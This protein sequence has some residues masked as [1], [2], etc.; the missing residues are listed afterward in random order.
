MRFFRVLFST[1]A[2]A[3]L[4]FNLV[5]SLAAGLYRPSISERGYLVLSAAVASSLVIFRVKRFLP[6]PQRD[7]PC[8][9][10][11]DDACV[12]SEHVSPVPPLLLI[13]LEEALERIGGVHRKGKRLPIAAEE[14]R[15]VFNVAVRTAA[16]ATAVVHM[17]AVDVSSR[18]HRRKNARRRV[19]RRRRFCVAVSKISAA[20]AKRSASR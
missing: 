9:S 16:Y 1:L 8:V 10:G 14:A 5:V 12:T 6:W 11:G 2:L 19:A 4:F 15:T 17:D 18:P 7:R 13:L 3:P 20:G